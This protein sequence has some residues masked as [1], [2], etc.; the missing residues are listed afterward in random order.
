MRSWYHASPFYQRVL[1]KVS[2]LEPIVAEAQAAAAAAQTQ[3]LQLQA[4]QRLGHIR[5]TA[6][7]GYEYMTNALVSSEAMSTVEE[8]A[9]HLAA[10]RSQATMADEVKPATPQEAATDGGQ[11]EME[12]EADDHGVVKAE[13]Q[14]QTGMEGEAGGDEVDNAEP[15][16]QPGK[17]DEA[18]KQGAVKTEPQE[19]PGTAGEG[20]PEEKEEGQTTGE[21]R[22][23]PGAVNDKETAAA[24]DAVR[25]PEPSA[26]H[27]E[28]EKRGSSDVGSDAMT[29]SEIKLEEAEA[30]VSAPAAEAAEASTRDKTATHSTSEPIVE[31]RPLLIPSREL[32]KEAQQPLS[33]LDFAVPAVDDAGTRGHRFSKIVLPWL[34]NHNLLLADLSSSMPPRHPLPLSLCAVSKVVAWHHHV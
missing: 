28:A 5:Q 33:I 25:V 31:S 2:A 16:Q 4:S 3:L 13:S 20:L 34:R 14:Q 11:V 32:P 10:V 24:A 15:Q 27:N 26:E 8:L 1:P 7:D 6:A 29:G 22:N 19:Q 21:K 18:E 30:A 9:A 17:D 23:E 12:D